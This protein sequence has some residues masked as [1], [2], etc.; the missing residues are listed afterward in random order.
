[1]HFTSIHHLSVDNF[2]LY[3]SGCIDNTLAD[4]LSK[5]TGLCWA[6]VLIKRTKY[7]Y[8]LRSYRVSC[9][10]GVQMLMAGSDLAM[11]WMPARV[12]AIAIPAAVLRVI[13]ALTSHII[14]KMFIVFP[15]HGT[16][17]NNS[18]STTCIGFNGVFAPLQASIWGRAMITKSV[19]NAPTHRPVN[20]M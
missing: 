11:G 3:F 4:S 18:L 13:V 6:V 9:G 1:M 5:L 20:F 16:P 2:L 12:A 15:I 17:I 14:L 19:R 7:G 10:H 8:I